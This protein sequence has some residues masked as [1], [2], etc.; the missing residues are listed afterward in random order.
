MWTTRIPRRVEIW[1]MDGVNKLEKATEFPS[2]VTVYN[3]P[4]RV[5]Q[6]TPNNMF[7]VLEDGVFRDSRIKMFVTALP[8]TK[9]RHFLNSALHD[10]Y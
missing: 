4:I 1:K 5:A 3:G 8:Q 6:V 7:F 10:E 2:S 9:L